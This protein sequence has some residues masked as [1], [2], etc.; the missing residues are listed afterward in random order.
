MGGKF[1]EGAIV[2][3][4]IDRES[5]EE[6]YKT[7]HTNYV[8]RFKQEPGFPGLISYNVTRVVID[9]I[10]NKAEGV[11]LK[12]A[13]LEQGTF[14]GVQ[15]KMQFDEYGDASSKT[16]ITEVINGRFVVQNK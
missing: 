13:I 4:Y 6:D 7:F 1:I 12:D 11:E 14:P 15:G 10:K 3:Q 16:Y 2:P 9:R 5:T 8:N